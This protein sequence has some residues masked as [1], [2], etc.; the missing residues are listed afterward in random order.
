M[1]TWSRA[2]L[3]GVPA[4]ALGA[5]GLGCHGTTR[6]EGNMSLAVTSSA[7][8][9]NHAVPREHTCDGQD[10]SP[11]LA[12]SGAPEAARGFAVVMD[13]PDAPRGT[14]VHWVLWNLP[15]AT[16][17]LPAGVP[18]DERLESG[19][20]QGR[21]DF[22]RIGWGGPCPPPGP[23]HHYSFR[24]YALDALLDLEPGA[25]KADLERAM[26]GHVLAQGEL[27]GTYSRLR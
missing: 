10:R 5:V 17:A 1:R 6:G 21:N 16:S 4:L 11:A 12:W 18:P 20:R 15:A 8:R 23:A 24:V 3:V 25:T 2:Y 19:A 22:R 27:V 14:W 26:R 9:A 13:D 7:F